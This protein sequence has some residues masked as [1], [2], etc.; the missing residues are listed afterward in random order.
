[1]RQAA[2]HAVAVEAAFEDGTV[3]C[4]PYA[5]WDGQRW[6]LAARH[7]RCV[8]FRLQPADEAALER[9]LAGARHGR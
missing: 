7:G 2:V 5:A 3:Q 9:V 4:M 8:S 6:S 1:V